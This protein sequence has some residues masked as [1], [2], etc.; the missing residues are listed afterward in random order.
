MYVTMFRDR[1]VDFRYVFISRNPLAVIPVACWKAAMPRLSIHSSIKTSGAS[2]GSEYYKPLTAIEQAGYLLSE[3]LFKK[4]MI[5]V[6]FFT[7]KVS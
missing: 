3:L 4:S 2:C 1:K 5:S 7:K 6:K